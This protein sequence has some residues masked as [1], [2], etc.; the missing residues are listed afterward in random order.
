MKKI[1]SIITPCFNEEENV[2]DVYQQVKEVFDDI[3]DFTYEHIFIDNASTDQTVQILKD[4]AKKNHNV[5]IIVNSRNFGVARSPYHALLQSRGDAAIVVMADLQDPPYL[6]KDL[7]KRWVDG[8]KIV[9]AIKENSEESKLM[10]NIRKLYYYIYNRLSN[11]Q[12]VQNYCGFGLY[13]KQIIDILR[14]FDDPYPDLRSLLGEMGFERASF[15]YVQPKR[16]K[17]ETKN[18]FYQLYDQAMLGITSDSIIPLRLASFIGFFIAVIN[19]LVATG[20]FIYKLLYWQNF[21]LGIAPLVIGIFFF[22]GIQLFFL[23]IIGEYIGIILTQVKKRPLVIEKER[24]NF[25]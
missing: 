3:K 9:F 4:I 16:K 24:I 12:I 11:V 2:L 14:R 7:I 8:Y 20:Y 19:I 25:D 1:V 15:T 17:G 10:F 18:S 21:Q 6:I 5:K 22:G 23:G 13:D